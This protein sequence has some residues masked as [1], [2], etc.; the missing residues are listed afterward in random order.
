MDAVGADQDV[1]ARRLPMRAAAIEEIGGDAAFIL[2]ER[3]EPATGVDGLNAQPLDHG[4]MNH[5]LQAT[6]V[7]GKLR[8]VVA[9]I[10]P[11]FFVPDLLAV[12]GQKKKLLG[13]GGGGGG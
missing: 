4:L 1:A 8:H 10:E 9:G 13:A 11:A 6:A 5:A 3:A 12:A 2:R 7:D